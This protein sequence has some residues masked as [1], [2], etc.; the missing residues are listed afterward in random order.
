MHESYRS[1]RSGG[2]LRRGTHEQQGDPDCNR[3]NAAFEKAGDESIRGALATDSEFR[4]AALLMAAIGVMDRMPA[5]IPMS[6]E[7]IT[8][9][10]QVELGFQRPRTLLAFGTR[11]THRDRSRCP[12]DRLARLSFAPPRFAIPDP[13]VVT[14]VRLTDAR[15]ARGG[16]F[17]HGR[18]RYRHPESHPAPAPAKSWEI[19]KPRLARGENVATAVVPRPFRR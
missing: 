8:N 13:A 12:R 16:G 2:S 5:T 3:N 10:S 6:K 18:V 19:G 17:D 15:V 14:E 9:L 11:A 4:R 7:R 1:S